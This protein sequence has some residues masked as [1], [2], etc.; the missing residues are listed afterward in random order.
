MESQGR[1][2]WSGERVPRAGPSTSAAA[3]FTS[4]PAPSPGGFRVK[5]FSV[6]GQGVGA[7][8]HAVQVKEKNSASHVSSSRKSSPSAHVHV[9]LAISIGGPRARPFF[10]PA[11]AVSSSSGIKRLLACSRS[12]VSSSAVSIL[13]MPLFSKLQAGSSGHADPEGPTT[14]PLT[15]SIDWRCEL[16]DALPG[17]LGKAL[18]RVVAVLIQ[19]MSRAETKIVVSTMMLM[20]FMP[21][22]T[23]LVISLM[24]QMGML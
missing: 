17:G 4:S 18:V 24:H 7:A 10:A 21:I 20:I 15:E 11:L 2:L 22:Q 23:F 12:E 9:L 13:R 8:M 6:H 3:A 5:R 1:L 19:A 16:E 14:L